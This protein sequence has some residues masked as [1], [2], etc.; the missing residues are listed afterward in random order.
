MIRV[1]RGKVRSNEVIVVPSHLRSWRRAWVCSHFCRC[2]I[3][4]LAR[5][6]DLHRSQFTKPA[7]ATPLAVV[8]LA[9]ARRLEGLRASE[10]RLVGDGVVI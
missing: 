8:G 3:N 1:S 6:V 9:N 10:L 7:L 2:H 4:E 5:N